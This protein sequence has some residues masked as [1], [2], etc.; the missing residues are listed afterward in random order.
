MLVIV[1]I[2]F[3]YHRNKLLILQNKECIWFYNDVFFFFFYS[4]KLPDFKI[5]NLYYNIITILLMNIS[6]VIII[7]MI[8]IHLLS[9]DV[10][11]VRGFTSY[12]IYL[13]YEFSEIHI[14]NGQTS[15][16]L[17]VQPV[18]CYNTLSSVILFEITT[19]ILCM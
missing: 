7:I 17:K 15:M 9:I 5:V 3:I 11:G 19:D 10:H 2:S 1:K 13:P 16:V 18:G 8:K 12:N 14:L 6:N 4:L